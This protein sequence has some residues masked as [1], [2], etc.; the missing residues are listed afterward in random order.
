MMSGLPSALTSAILTDCA[1]YPPEP[2]VTAGRNETDVAGTLTE[3]GW[4]LET[5]PPG[6]GLTTVT[7]AVDALV[8][9]EARTVA[10]SLALLTKVGTR[11]L[12]FQFTTDAGTNP[13]PFTVRVNAAP[14][15]AAASGTSG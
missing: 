10:V 12:P 8:M 9:S 1:M 11:G 13:A 6:L 15:G 2:Y 5:P 7:A 3:K 4:M 14:P